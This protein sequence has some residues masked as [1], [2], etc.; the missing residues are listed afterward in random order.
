MIHIAELNTKKSFTEELNSS[1][2]Y[3]CMNAIKHLKNEAFLSKK[4]FL[5][6]VKHEATFESSIL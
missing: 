5:I 1:L 6:F 3:I 4:M 2:H